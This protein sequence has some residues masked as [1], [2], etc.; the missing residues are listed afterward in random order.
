MKSKMKKIIIPLASVFAI[1]ILAVAVFCLK[2]VSVN[3]GSSELFSE[4][5]IQSA[6]EIV[7]A[8][9]RDFDGCKLISLS[10]AGDDKCLKEADGRTGYDKVIV[11]KSV[12][13]SPIRSKDAGAWEPH[14][15]YYN[16]SFTVGIQAEG[17]QMVLLN[18]GY[19]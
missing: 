2:P 11:F 13:L 16:Y 19:A 6:A 7:K 8:K 3:C 5:E 9:F 15:I 14:S 10:F 4:D 12:F 18:Y 17:N 1:L